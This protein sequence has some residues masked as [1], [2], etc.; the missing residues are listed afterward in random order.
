MG[1]GPRNLAELQRALT[2]YDISNAMQQNESGNTAVLD[3]TKKFD[4]AL[5]QCKIKKLQ[6]HVDLFLPE[7]NRFILAV[8]KL[9]ST[10]V[11]HP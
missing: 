7:G 5:H 4:E 1:L 9:L 10:K 11:E 6:Y 3:F 2:I 8:S